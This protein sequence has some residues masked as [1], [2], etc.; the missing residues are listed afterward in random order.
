M[1]DARPSSDSDHLHAFVA[2]RDTA[3]P[4]CGYNTRGLKTTRCP[5]CDQELVLEL[6][7]AEPRVGAWLTAVAGVFAGAVGGGALVAAVIITN[8][9]KGL[10]VRPGKPAWMLHYL[11]TGALVVCGF[12]AAL[13]LR[14][15][16]RRWFRSLAPGARRLVITGCWA[17]SASFFGAMLAI[18]LTM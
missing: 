8:W 11:P 18:M 9:I 10:P 15:G 1:G 17:L 4:S 7:M 14:R 12:C 3:C 16:G 6:R 2:E 5:E 13:L